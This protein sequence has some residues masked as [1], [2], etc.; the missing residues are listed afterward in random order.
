MRWGESSSVV[1][2]FVPNVMP[3]LPDTPRC[4]SAGQQIF[5]QPSVIASPSVALFALRRAVAGR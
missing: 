2:A 1:L 5:S 3:R 4:G